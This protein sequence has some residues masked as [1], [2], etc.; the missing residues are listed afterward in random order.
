MPHPTT[1]INR[2]FLIFGKTKTLNQYQ[3]KRSFLKK[4]HVGLN[5][6]EPE[7]NNLAMRLKHLLN[8]K[9]K[10]NNHGGCT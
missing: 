2:Y 9:Q 5:I 1:Y 3:E 6:K 7:S 4:E 10:N 8:L